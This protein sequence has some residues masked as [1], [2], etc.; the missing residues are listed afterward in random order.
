MATSRGLAPSFARHRARGDTG[1]L[2]ESAAASARCV[3]KKGAAASYRASGAGTRE[4]APAVAAGRAG[5][6]QPCH[7]AAA[8]TLTME[9]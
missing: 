9:K 1:A 7:L 8:P 3:G 5:R 2:D 4:S 6:I